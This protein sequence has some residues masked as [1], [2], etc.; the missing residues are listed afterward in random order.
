MPRGVPYANDPSM[1]VGRLNWK[2]AERLDKDRFFSEPGFIVGIW[3]LR[4][5]VYISQAASAIGL[6]THG[7]RWLPAQLQGNPETSLHFMDGETAGDYFVNYKP[8]PEAED[9]LNG[10][11]FD[12]RDLLVYG[13]QNFSGFT[14]LTEAFGLVS[15]VDAPTVDFMRRF[16]SHADVDALWL[17]EEAYEET[18]DRTQLAQKAFIA[19]GVV[20][21]GIAS[22]ITDTSLRG[23]QVNLDVFGEGSGGGGSSNPPA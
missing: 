18:P 5:K 1:T 19:E 4:P 11:W 8:E 9:P 13:E 6:L 3:V 12:V 7:M 14:N 16:A 17:D 22:R 10:I 15:S 21:F 2:I 23:G 20:Q